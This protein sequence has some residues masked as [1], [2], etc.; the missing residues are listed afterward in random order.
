MQK[1]TPEI[2]IQTSQLWET[3]TGIIHGPEG[4]ILVDPGVFQLEFEAIA[5]AAGPIAAGFCTHAHWD[6]LLWDGALDEDAPRFATAETIALINKDRNKILR[7]LTDA[8]AYIA[9]TGQSDGSELWDRSQLFKEQPI[10]WGVGEIASVTVEIIHV[11][12]HEDGQGALVLPDYGVAFVADTLSDIETPSVHGGYRA[13]ALYLHTLNRLQ[14][15]ID[16][17]EWIIPGHGKPANRAEAQRRLDADRHYLEGIAP[18]VNAGASGEGTE[19]LARRVLA[20]LGEERAQSELAWSMHLD[21]VSQLVAERTQLQSD[22]PV[23]RSSRLILL[24]ADN[25]VWMLRINDPVRPRWILPGGGVEEGETREDAARRELWE[26]CAIDDAEIGPMVATRESLGKFA[27]SGYHRASEQYFV[28]K[29]NGKSPHSLNMTAHEQSHYS[30]GRWLSADDIRA[31]NE[32]V[33]PL[34]LA[35]LLDQLSKGEIPAVPWV[36]RD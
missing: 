13:I 5:H 3:N 10:A 34:G 29:L 16:R 8:E 31:S 26:E 25:R 18:L 21:N 20:E 30:T 27:D 4:A 15:I 11:P 19:D 24:G 12:G 22:L 17:V 28:V 33:H 2:T 36:W 1:P 6:H 7:N 32:V 35:D 14:A 23:R 9:S